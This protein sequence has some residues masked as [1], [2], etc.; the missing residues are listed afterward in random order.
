SLSLSQAL[1]D[2]VDRVT[3]LWQLGFVAWARCQYV[4]ARAQLEEALVLY[5]NLGD[6]FNEA[7]TLAYLARVFAAQGEY[8]QARGLAEESLE[9]A[10]EIDAKNLIASALE[11]AGTVVT[12]QGEP[13]WAARLWGT[14]QALRGA[15]GAP[16]PPVYRADYEAALHTTRT[17]L[18]E[19]VFATALAEGGDMILEQALDTLLLLFSQLDKKFIIH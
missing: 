2:P 15:I 6:T 3:I 17:R 7:R 10:R 8:G 1:G 19:E 4:E 9:L 5:H 18:G 13:E 16:L 11:G 14:A 12:A